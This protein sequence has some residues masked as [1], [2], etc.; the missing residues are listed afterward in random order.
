MLGKQLDG[1]EALTLGGPV[2]L[3]SVMVSTVNSHCSMSTD[4]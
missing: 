2:T 3:A 1:N 4:T